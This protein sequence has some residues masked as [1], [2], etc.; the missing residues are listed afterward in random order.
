M[1]HDQLS[2]LGSMVAAQ[3]ANGQQQLQT[4][5]Q[6]QQNNA[7]QLCQP[8]TP[9]SPES[10]CDDGSDMSDDSHNPVIYPWMK[11]IHVAGARKLPSFSFDVL[12]R[13]MSL[14]NQLCLIRREM[15]CK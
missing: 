5:I 8:P 1:Q 14:T 7:L 6:Q 9:N 15:F 4:Q 12:H 11:K 10:D 13:K 2:H 3:Q